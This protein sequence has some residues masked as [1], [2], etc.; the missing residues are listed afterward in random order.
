MVVRKVF[1]S[2]GIAFVYKKRGLPH[3]EGDLFGTMM[4]YEVGT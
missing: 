4:F 3:G 1:L 2:D